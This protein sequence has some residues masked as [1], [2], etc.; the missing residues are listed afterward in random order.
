[1]PKIQ[2][3]AGKGAPEY[4]G[5]GRSGIEDLDRWHHAE[6]TSRHH[7]R[8]EHRIAAPLVA[9]ADHRQGGRHEQ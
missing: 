9:H 4:G 2:S 3:P 7:Q 8:G 1:M 6:T 5:H